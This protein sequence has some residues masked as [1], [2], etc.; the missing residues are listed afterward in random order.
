MT[1][2]TDT[3]VSV[4]G[5]LYTGQFEMWRAYARVIA[6]GNSNTKAFRKPSL[7]V[8]EALEEFIEQRIARWDRSMRFPNPERFGL[9]RLS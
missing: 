2:T 9:T 3:R 4:L 8:S 1:A 5:N 6:L 7:F